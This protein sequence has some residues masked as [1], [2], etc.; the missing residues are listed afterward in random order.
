VDVADDQGSP[1]SQGAE[2]DC[3]D[4]CWLF[5]RAVLRDRLGQL[6]QAAALYERVGGEGFRVGLRDSNILE[7]MYAKLR[8]GPLYEQMGD[9]VRAVEA[10]QRLVDQW[11]DGDARAQETVQRFRERVAELGG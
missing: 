3:T 1:A 9:T 7:I 11:A 5:E 8:L 6:E 10:Y 4:A 2:E